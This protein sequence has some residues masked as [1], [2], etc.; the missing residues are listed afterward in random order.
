MG[1][2][3]KVK[4]DVNSIED[5]ELKEATEIELKFMRSR[6]KIKGMSVF[7]IMKEDPPRRILIML[8]S[9]CWMVKL[10]D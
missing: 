6:R 4:F 7:E 9:I 3:R 5:K 8:N 1:K 10:M 2:R